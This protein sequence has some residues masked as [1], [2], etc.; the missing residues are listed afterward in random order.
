[1]VYDRTGSLPIA[2]LMHASLSACTF[3]LSPSMVTG[4][5]F[6]TYGFALAA[7]WWIVV[8]VVGAASRGHVGM[9]PTAP[10]VQVRIA[11]GS[12]H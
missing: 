12:L 4:L 2:M 8:A 9:R 10:A 1:L 6:V 3:I 5:S 7:A 11:P